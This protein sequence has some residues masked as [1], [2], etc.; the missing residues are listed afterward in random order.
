MTKIKRKQF[1]VLHL[2]QNG[3]V[4]NYGM[5]QPTAKDEERQK[6]LEEAAPMSISSSNPFESKKRHM[7]DD[8]PRPVRSKKISFKPRQ[9][10]YS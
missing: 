1:G 8:D 3:K 5:L 2:R 7:E 6:A 10:L 9:S 4:Y